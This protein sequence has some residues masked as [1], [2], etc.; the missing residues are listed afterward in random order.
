[1]NFVRS[2]QRQLRKELREKSLEELMEM[3]E[4]LLSKLAE[5]GN[6][7]EKSRSTMPSCSERLGGVRFASE[8]YDEL[9]H[10]RRVLCAVKNEISERKAEK[11]ME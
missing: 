3:E 2:T 8:P 4:A 7:K 5:K 11:T 10:Y 9:D 1:M 6:N